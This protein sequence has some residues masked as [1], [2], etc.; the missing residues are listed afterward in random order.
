MNREY[1]KICLE[2]ILGEHGVEATSEQIEAM[3]GD[4]ESCA[5]VQGEYEA[6]VENPLIRETEIL[7]KALE[8]EKAKVVCTVCNGRGR[9]IEQFSSSHCSDSDCW[10]CRGAGRI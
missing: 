10:K 3:A 9:L 6:P 1:W 5:S 7:R 4:F 2:E 8:V